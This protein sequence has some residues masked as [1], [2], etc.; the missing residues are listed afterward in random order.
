MGRGVSGQRL[1]VNPY[2]RRVPG[3]ATH[4]F[5]QTDPSRVFELSPDTYTLLAE[6]T[7]PQ[8]IKDIVG[9]IDE[10]VAAIFVQLCDLRILVPV[11]GEL[12]PR[13]P[14]RSPP[15]VPLCGAPTWPED[16]VEAQLEAGAVVVLGARFDDHTLPEY[17]RGAAAGP[18]AIRQAS[19]GYPLRERLDDGRSLGLF[20][21]DLGRRLLAGARVY[22]AGDLRGF[23]GCTWDEY[24]SALTAEL[25]A[26]DARG[27]RVLLLGGDHSVSLPAL[28]ARPAP[29]A[30]LHI[31]AHTDAAHLRYQGDL[32]HGNFL[33]HAARLGALRQIVSL[34]IRGFQDT[35]P[36][37]EGVPY[38]ARSPTQLRGL[39]DDALVALLAP[40]LPV[41]VS[42]DIDALDPAVAPATPAPEPG[43]FAIAELRRLL[44]VCLRDRH[45]VGADLVEVQG[46]RD[47]S[48][49]TA[50]AALLLAV[51]LMDLLAR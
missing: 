37:I 9:E 47:G 40:D 46:G 29:F 15:T 42:V 19:A 4:A 39:D 18:E 36:E 14:R 20:D 43:G 41:Y 25:K 31:D 24:A 2:L 22:D 44:R 49:L 13:P 21:L 12:G 35:P 32:H 45:V 23:P 7:T 1:Q 11:G 8:T 38:L 51:D 30:L 3:S 16:H 34:G 26:I 33:R 27:G 50:K 6:F 5:V 17:A 48:A 10:S 28:L